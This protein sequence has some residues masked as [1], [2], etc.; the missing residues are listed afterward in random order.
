MEPAVGIFDAR[1]VNR[2]QRDTNG[3]EELVL[4]RT[5]AQT[6]IVTLNRPDVLNSFNRS[7]AHQLQSILE[8]LGNDDNVRCIVLTGAGR[9]FCAGQDLAEVVPAKGEKPALGSIV[10]DCYNPIVRRLRTMEKP[11]VSAVNG[12]AAGAG[13]NLAFACDLVYAS[14]KSSFIQSFS[15][16]GLIPDTGGTYFLPRLVGLRRATQLMMLG[17]RLAPDDA[18][19]LGLLSGVYPHDELLEKVTEV[20][21]SLAHMPTRGLGLTKRALNASF[22]NDLDAQLRLEADLQ[23]IAGESHDYAEGVDAF[24]N[25]RQPRFL[26]R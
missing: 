12:V 3:M 19:R 9:A 15:K 24:M 6:A 8:E 1:R 5:E 23:Q 25:K 22:D 7:M 14:D 18:L 16:V 10:D 20:A 26:G 21:A 2:K 4:L 13:A 11:I 17:D